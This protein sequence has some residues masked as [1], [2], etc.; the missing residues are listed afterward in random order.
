MSDRCR[1]VRAMA[2]TPTRWRV[3]QRAVRAAVA[4]YR[5]S[6]R[7]APVPP[8]VPAKPARYDPFVA[9]VAAIRRFGG[10]DYDLPPVGPSSEALA[11]WDAVGWLD[12]YAPFDRIMF[13]ADGED[14]AEELVEEWLACL[15]P[16][17]E[18]YGL[19]LT[20]ETVDSSEVDP[21]DRFPDQGD[22]VLLLNGVRCRIWS[23][24]EWDYDAEPAW[25]PWTAATLRPLAVV[26]GLLAA[27]ASPVRAHVLDAGGNDAVVILVD[28]A[29][30]TAMRDSGDYPESAIPALVAE[31]R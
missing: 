20:V 5:R 3:F 11:G 25:D 17:L 10:D 29:I 27:C 15:A 21:V 1:S 16:A 13:T 7:P 23:G 4:E 18:H 28:P 8:A 2:I 30:V 14:L 19:P 24:E 12:A 6:R 9:I 31:P 22:Y 26:N